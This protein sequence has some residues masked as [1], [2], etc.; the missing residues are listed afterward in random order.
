[1]LRGERV[2]GLTAN[3]Y[4]VRSARNWGVGDLGDLRA[5][6]RF[7]HEVGAAFVGVNPLHALRNADG[8]V[9]PYSPISRVFR[10][11]LY[12]DVEAV[13]ELADA[14]EARALLA[15][16]AGRARKAR[17]SASSTG[18]LHAITPA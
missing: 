17:C 8:D 16:P 5:L 14:P 15:S 4:T 12:L 3:L 1:M 9:S 11:V 13:P 7:A 6:T 2:V 10:N 18:R